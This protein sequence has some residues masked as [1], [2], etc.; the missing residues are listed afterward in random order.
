MTE[1]LKS[2]VAQISPSTSGLSAMYAMASLPHA[3]LR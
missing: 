3:D 2:I 1:R